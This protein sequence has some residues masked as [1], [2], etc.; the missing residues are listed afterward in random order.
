VPKRHDDL[1]QPRRRRDDPQDRPH[2]VRTAP[3]RG[4]AP[5]PC[6]SPVGRSTLTL[7]VPTS[8]NRW[9]ARTAPSSCPH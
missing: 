1:A 9:G 2:V 8:A 3:L 5:K 7:R 4:A 6:R